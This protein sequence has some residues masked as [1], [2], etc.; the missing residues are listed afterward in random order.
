MFDVTPASL[1]PRIIDPLSR[2]FGADAA[3]L[4]I[5]MPDEMVDLSDSAVGL[6]ARIGE[7]CTARLDEIRT[8]IANGTYL[9]NHKLDVV[10]GMIHADLH[11][12]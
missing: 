4:K 11:A 9:T 5:V 12:R 6:D 8:Q 3:A 7:S 2:T 1:A 10:A